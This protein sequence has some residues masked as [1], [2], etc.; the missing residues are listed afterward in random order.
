ML[1]VGSV[2]GWG[3][4]VLGRGEGGELQEVDFFFS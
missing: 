3:F 2:G 1:D 4:G